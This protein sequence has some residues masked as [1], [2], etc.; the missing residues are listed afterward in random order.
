VCLFPPAGLPRIAAAERLHIAP[1]TV[2]YR[3]RRAEALLGRT[4]GDDKLPLRLA[5]EISNRLI[6]PW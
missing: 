2:A 1:T 6:L 4:L 5:L 3:V